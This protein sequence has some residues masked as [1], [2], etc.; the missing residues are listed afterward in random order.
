MANLL[1]RW[2]APLVGG[3]AIWLLS[4]PLLMGHPAAASHPVYADGVAIAKADAVDHRLVRQIEQERAVAA[5]AVALAAAEALAQAAKA[6][7]E[8]A[9]AA[10]A[11]AAPVVQAAPPPNRPAPAPVAVRANTIVIA[12]LGLVQPVGWYGDCLGRA[13]VPRWGSWRWSCAGSNNIYVMAHNPGTFTPILGLRAGDIVQYGDPS[14]R[15]HTY[16]VSYTTIVNNTQMWPLG[17][18]SAASLTLQTCW[19]W[20]GSRDFIVR[21][22]EI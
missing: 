19:T 8:A 18:T 20:D 1:R 7:A 17:A 3:V 6:A 15:V 10:A 2:R 22:L 12:R 14:G 4:F 9:A 21:A 5:Q 16:R 13:A 11:Q